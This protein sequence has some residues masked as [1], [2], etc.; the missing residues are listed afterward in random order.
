MTRSLA[1]MLYHF[2]SLL[3]TLKTSRCL[4][5]KQD[6]HLFQ[7]LTPRLGEEEDIRQ[8]S[9]QIENKEDIEIAEPN[10]RQ[11]IRRELRKDQIDSPIRERGNRV[12]LVAD[13]NGENLSRVNPRD[14]TDEC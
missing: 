14:D 13:I 7:R 6:I 3:L 2:N 11:G 10:S 5:P 12:T 8:H 1:S 4:I 9:D